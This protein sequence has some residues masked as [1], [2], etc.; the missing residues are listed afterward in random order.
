MFQVDSLLPCGGP[1][2]TTLETDAATAAAA[3]SP[4]P[5]ASLLKER[6][7]AIAKPGPLHHLIE[8]FSS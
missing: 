5:T 2:S 1:D 7:R 3:P 8:V 4:L 6:A